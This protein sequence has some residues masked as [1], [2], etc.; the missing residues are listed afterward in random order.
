MKQV[1]LILAFFNSFAASAQ[2]IRKN[3]PAAHQQLWVGITV[4][5]DYNNRTLSSDGSMAADIVKDSRDKKEIGQAGYT[6]GL[7]V[8]YIFTEAWSIEAGVQYAQKGY[9][10]KKENLVW[11]Q[12]SPAF[13]T[14]SKFIYNY[15][16][17]DIPLQV[18][19]TTGTGNCRFFYS[20]GLAFN[21]LLEGE[22]TGIFEYADGSKDKSTGPATTNEKKL[23]LSPLLSA[24]IDYRFKPNMHFRL[25]PVFRYGI[26]KMIDAPVSERL[27][28][29]G[30]NLGFYYRLL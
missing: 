12:P 19:Y 11:P 30:L 6:A 15:F 8:N 2:L 1:I 24:G 17:L 29:A 28:N 14:T 26:T 25:A 7:A 21:I 20:A 23:S 16:F 13:P 27:W 5:P 18:K 22:A 4:S 10:T 3:K 9:R